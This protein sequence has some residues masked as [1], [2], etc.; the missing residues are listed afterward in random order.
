[1]SVPGPAFEELARERLL[2]VALETMHVGHLLDRA[3]MPQVAIA[4]RD[5]DVV[6]QVLVNRPRVDEPFDR[7][8]RSVIKAVG[9]GLRV[10]NPGLDPC[11]A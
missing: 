5:V 1:M 10:W 7:V 8:N 3:I 9:L 2:P 4:A 11:A 6:D